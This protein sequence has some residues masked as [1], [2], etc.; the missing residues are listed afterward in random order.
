MSLL[1]VMDFNFI[2]LETVTLKVKN[3]IMKDMSQFFPI[4]EEKVQECFVLFLFSLLI[5]LIIY[6][7]FR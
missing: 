1:N 4:F 7:I 6:L 3:S 2:I 5:I